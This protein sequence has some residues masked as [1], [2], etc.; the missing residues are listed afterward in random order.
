MN[1]HTLMYLA[2]GYLVAVNLV[3]FFVYG[4]DKWKAKRSKW[5][6]SEATLLGLAAVGGSVGAWMG[7]NVWHHKTLHRKFKYGVPLILFAQ[8]ALLFFVSCGTARTTEK[9]VF[10]PRKE[11]REHSASVL[12][13]MYDKG[14]GKSFLMKAIKK[15]GAEIV[16]DYKTISGMAIRKPDDKTLEAT[17]RYFETVEGVVSVE[18]DYINHLVEPVKPKMETE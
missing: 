6:I 10:L 18:Y 7:M 2:V 13:V 9:M 1:E 8:I 14:I 17:K 11:V 12:I 4:I 16:Y 5:R 15:Y 3:A